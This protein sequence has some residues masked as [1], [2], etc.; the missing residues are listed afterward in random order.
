[1][2]V[3]IGGDNGVY[4]MTDAVADRLIAGLAQI[5]ETQGAGLAVTASR[6]TSPAIVARLRQALAKLP[7]V[8]WDNTGENPYFGYLGL[9]DHV[10]V[11]GDSVS[12]VSEACAT[13]KPVH[14]IDRE[15]GSRKF[16]S[17]HAGLRADGLT[18]AFAAPL[19]SW[20]YPPLED[21]ALV[22]AEVRR[23]LGLS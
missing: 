17:F 8:M 9:A 19:A 21:T 23:Q 12:M 18:R 20:T 22:A 6:R 10:V 16:E 5:V 2:A 3:L 13:G 4:R 11:T 1:M 7:A 14:V 15:G